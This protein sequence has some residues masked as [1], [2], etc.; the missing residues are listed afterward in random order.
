VPKS[1][2]Q[3]MAD[4]CGLCELDVQKMTRKTQEILHDAG[5]EQSKESI[6][7]GMIEAYPRTS[8]AVTYAECLASYA[9]ARQKGMSH[10]E[11]MMGLKEFLAALGVH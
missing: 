8:K 2:S 4:L 3:R 1:D 11:A 5:I 10:Y 7:A 6:L 9:T